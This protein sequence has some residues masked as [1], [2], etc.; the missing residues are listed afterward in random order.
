MFCISHKVFN[1]ISSYCTIVRR[2]SLVKRLFDWFH[3]L[4]VHDVLLFHQRGDRELF[5]ALR[6]RN[7]STSH[8]GQPILVQAQT[9]FCDLVFQNTFVFVCLLGLHR[10]RVDVEVFIVDDNSAIEIL[11]LFLLAHLFFESYAVA[12]LEDCF[13]VALL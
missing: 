11:L 12:R 1:F 6:R 7:L 2:F 9:D 8:L 13:E 4:L 10:F 5:Q 3:S